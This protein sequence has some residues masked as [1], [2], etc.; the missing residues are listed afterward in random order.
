MGCSK[1]IN[2]AIVLEEDEERE[3]IMNKNILIN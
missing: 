3:R 1:L 2:A